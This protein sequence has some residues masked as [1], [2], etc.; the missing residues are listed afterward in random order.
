MTICLS[1]V[2]FSC[3]SL[4]CGLQLVRQF[5]LGRPVLLDHGIVDLALDGVALRHAK[6]PP[7]LC[8]LFRVARGRPP[9]FFGLGLVVPRPACLTVCI[10][11]LLGCLWRSPG[12]GSRSCGP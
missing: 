1:F 3:I 2:T 5:G 11:N 12:S 6:A 7:T 8:V 4:V 9:L 10:P